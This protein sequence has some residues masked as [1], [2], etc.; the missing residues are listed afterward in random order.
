MA[1]SRVNISDTDALKTCFGGHINGRVLYQQ[2]GHSTYLP[3]LSRTMIVS[4]V[5]L[6]YIVRAGGGYDSTQ[7][8]SPFSI[9]PGTLPL[10]ALMD[11][12]PRSTHSRARGTVMD[13]MLK[14]V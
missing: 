4:L 10:K 12:G 7:T 8:R 3:A 9:P 2:N 14:D 13:V 5:E 6:V 11:H 1:R